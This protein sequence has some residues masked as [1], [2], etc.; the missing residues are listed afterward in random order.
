MDSWRRHAGSR[1]RRHDAAECTRARCTRGHTGLRRVTRQRGQ[2]GGRSSRP[3]WAGAASSA[4]GAGPRVPDSA[5]SLTTRWLTVGRNRSACTRSGA[6]AG[7]W[8]SESHTSAASVW[9]QSSSA[10]KIYR[11][12]YSGCMVGAS[13]KVVAPRSSQRGASSVEASATPTQSHAQSAVAKVKTS[14]RARLMIRSYAS[15]M[16][17][18]ASSGPD[19]ALAIARLRNKRPAKPPQAPPSRPPRSTSEG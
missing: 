7:P 2:R 15:P 8:P 19:S 11:D 12:R 10:A 18:L 13:A 5:A 1:R 6:G 16:P 14:R 3:A 17:G 9:A 4:R